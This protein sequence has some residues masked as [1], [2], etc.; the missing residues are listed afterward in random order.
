MDPVLQYIA[1]FEPEIRERLEV[2]RKLFLETLPGTEE[3]IRY[4][5]PA[6]TVGKHHLYFA[7]YKRHI[8]FYPVYGLAAIEREIEHYKARR[9]KDTLHFP[10]DQP[11]PLDLVKKIILLKAT[12]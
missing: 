2:L 7:G 8:G 9:T 4:G 10:H 3:S 6:Y 11:L 1:G 12:Q 5:M